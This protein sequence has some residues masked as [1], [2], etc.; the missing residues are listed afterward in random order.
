[1]ERRGP[2]FFWESNI[3]SPIMV[4]WKSELLNE[5]FNDHVIGDIAIFHLHDGPEEE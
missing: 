3:F 2:R 1:M 5:R 4:Q